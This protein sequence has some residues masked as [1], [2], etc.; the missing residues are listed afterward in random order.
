M[1][2]IVIGCTHAG[3]SAIMSLKKE[4][5]DT[6]ITVYEKNDNISF[7]SCGIA[8]YVEGIVKDP[9]SLFYSSPEELSTIGVK[10][11][12]KH[13]VIDI[14]VNNKKLKIKNL[15]D[16]TLIE[17][18]YDKLITTIGSWP[19][20]PKIDGINLNN[21]LLAK[22]Y[23]HSNKIINRAKDAKMI[24]VIGAGYIGVELAEAFK[25]Q[26]KKVRLIDAQD[27]ILKQ[28]LDKE[29]TD[30]AQDKISSND[31]ELVLGEKI[32]GFAGR[33]GKVAKVKTTHK[34]FETDLVIMC[35]GFRPNTNILKNKVD[36]LENGSILVN[37]YLQTSNPDIFAAGDCCSV[38]YNPTDQKQ[39]IPL[40]TNA[41]RMGTLIGKNIIENKLPYLGTQGTSGIKIFDYNIAS[42]GL[43]EFSARESNLD[44]ETSSL[45]DNYRPEF[46][47]EHELVKLKIIYEKKTKVL[48]GAQILSKADLTQS[49]NT[50][51]VCIQKKM[52]IEELA[53]T[54]FFFQPHYNK[55]WNFLN[56]VALQKI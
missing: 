3:T 56:T 37:K 24:T 32:K 2:I 33:D 7:L 18:S 11:K 34:T 19:I 47:P 20:V 31:I 38:S 39:Y 45:E 10:T 6:M 46:M 53:F 44:I 54:D 51:S 42:T 21:I 15:E 16:N 1:K 30:L 22:N 29:F 5:P 52:T 36:M 41:I 35:I 43:T 50:L 4:Y 9:K 26:G 13:E 14:D 12:M 27:R 40:A 49:I 8:L 48:L 28:Y 17:D 55:P 23:Y 25:N